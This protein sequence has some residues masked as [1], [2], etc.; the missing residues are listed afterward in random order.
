MLAPSMAGLGAL[1]APHTGFAE[2]P[3]VDVSGL[4][5]EHAAD[6]QRS[7]DE[8]GRACADAGFCYVLGH[9]VTDSLCDRLVQQAG[10]FFAQPLSRKLELYIGKSP[11]H[12]GYV[13]PGEEV[14]YGGARDQKEAFDLCFEPAPGAAGLPLGKN[15]FAG[16]NVW[17]ELVAFREVVTEYYRAVFELGQTLFRGFSLALG[18]PESFFARFVTAPP[19]QLRLLHY[20]DGAAGDEATIGIGAH[21]DYECFTILLPTAPGLE[22]MNGA[23][24]WIDAPPLPGAFIVNIGDTLE[25]FTNGALTATS[26]RVRKLSYERYSFPL[27]FSCDY[28]TVVAPLP[29][30]VSAE[31]PARYPTIVAGE[32][33]YAQTV[34]SFRYMQERLSRGDIALP[35]NARPLS[36]FGQEGKLLHPGP[37]ASDES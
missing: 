5:S 31:R 21:T 6:R 11:N 1:S 27:F 2:L 25:T 19:S 32:H 16:P 13:P 29:S 20:P 4:Y 26:H 9:R 18:L 10:A 23:G 30:F 35:K 3:R 33:L 22:V 15:P 7:A 8:L 36:S 24:H 17:P 34:Q 28:D 12:R 37:S 14:F